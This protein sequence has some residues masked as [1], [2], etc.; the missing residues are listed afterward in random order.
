MPDQGA[1]PATI[2]PGLTSMADPRH[3]PAV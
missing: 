3:L 1:R 2:E